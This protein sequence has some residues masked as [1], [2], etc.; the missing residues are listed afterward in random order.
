MAEKNERPI[1]CSIQSM[2]RSRLA[3]PILFLAFAVFLYVFL[4][5]SAVFTP[6]TVAT[7]HEITECNKNGEEFLTLHMDDLYF[8]GYSE[9]FAGRIRGYY[10]Y[11]TIDEKCILF[12]LSPSTCE[13]GLSQISDV[14][15]SGKLI[16]GH[17][18]Y[19]ILLEQIAADLNWTDTGIKQSVPAFY[20]SETDRHFG[21]SCVLLV[22]L[23]ITV[24]YAVI[25]LIR[26]TN[27]LI[28]PARSSAVKQLGRYGDPIGL[29]S[30]AEEELATLPQLAT[31]DMFI[32]EHFFIMLSKRKIAI[33]PIQEILWIYKHSTLH[34]TLWR[35][36]DISYTLHITARQNLYVNCPKNM[37]SDIDGIIDYLSEANHDIL[38]GFNEKNQYIVEH[39]KR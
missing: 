7:Y 12:L 6:V 15:F 2:Y 22:L 9:N 29:L 27:C 31:E 30:Q 10:Y 16:E 18:H 38:V 5:V 23:A 25:S 37:K 21:L 14:S 1:S 8:T 17:H 13:R 4:P 36:I 19:Q 34:K 11:G 39:I 3:A 32:T 26:I 28:F 24:L 35:H 20:I 33:I